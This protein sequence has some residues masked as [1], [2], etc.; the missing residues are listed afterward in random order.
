MLLNT[1]VVNLCG[2]MVA[3]MWRETVRAILSQIIR[4]LIE[5]LIL[6]SSRRRICSGVKL[7]LIFVKKKRK[8]FNVDV[9]VD[10]NFIL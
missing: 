3:G 8:W 4:A 10:I 5:I 9:D 1:A 6:F 2:C 7:L